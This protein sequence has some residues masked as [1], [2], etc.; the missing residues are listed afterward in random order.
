MNEYD[1]MA[2][3]FAAKT[4]TRLTIL[5]QDYKVMEGW[6]DNTP[7][8]VFRC[9][10]SRKGQSYTFEFG[11]SI[12]AGTKR[13][14]MYDV[15]ACLQKYDVGSFQDFCEEFG[16]AYGPT[17]RKTYDA[18]VREYKAVLRLFGDVM[19]ELCDIS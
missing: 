6:G 15:L 16:Y 7:R 3:D 8:C 13:P 2:K 5:D 1:K 10:L 12:A 9:R 14:T 17:A 18:V 11:R 19:D 4:G